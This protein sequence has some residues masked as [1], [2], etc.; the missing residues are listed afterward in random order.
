MKKKNDPKNQKVIIINNMFTGG[1]GL[2]GE[3]LPHEMI[4]FFRDKNNGF[5]V[6]ITPTGTINKS[7]KEED[8]RAIIFI[9]NYENGM[10]EVLGKAEGIQPKKFYTQG[11]NLDK[12]N[13]IKDSNGKTAATIKKELSD[14]N[15]SIFYGEKSLTD[16]HISNASDNGIL[17]SMTVD[18]ICLPQKTFYLSYK[19]EN[20][21]LFNDVYFL[22]SDDGNGPGKQIA[23]QS[24]LAYYYETDNKYA[25]DKLNEI[26]KDDKNEFWE[27]ES[28]TPEYNAAEIDKDLVGIDNF[29]KITRQQ[30]N[31][32]MFS[33][34]FFYYFST[35]PKLLKYFVKEILGLELSESYTVERE[36]ERMDIRIIDDNHYIIIENKIKSGINGIIKKQK[37]KNDDETTNKKP[38]YQYTEDGFAIDE[39]GKYISQLSVYLEKAKNHLEK[40]KKTDVEIKAFIF[41]PNYSPLNK[42]LLDNKYSCGKEY[43]II[44]Y[45]DIEKAF[46]SYPGDKPP[47]FQDFLYALNKHTKTIDDEH[48]LNLLYRLKCR[49]EDN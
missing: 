43:S 24:M 25:Y 22:P 8:I 48:R 42:D 11:I 6:Y 1:Y 18:K 20:E 17:V 2:N 44:R 14:I 3:N 23:N 38:G 36:K 15:K 33:N 29:F 5:N 9:R 39:N 37:G 34:M 13:Q 30:D 19:P 40:E 4:N 16:I 32:V 7:I 47:Y 28:K 10:V 12:Q 26:L 27:N 49:I 31:E 41:A 45:K 21:K 35:C 46:H